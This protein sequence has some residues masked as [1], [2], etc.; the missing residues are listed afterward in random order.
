MLTTRSPNG[1][2]HSR[3]MSPGTLSRSLHAAAFVL[4]PLPSSADSAGLV[5]TFVANSVSLDDRDV[6]HHV[7]V[8]I[9]T[10]RALTTV[11]PHRSL[12]NSMISSTIHLSTSRSLIPLPPTGLPSL[13]RQPLSPTT[14][15]SS[16]S[17]TRWSRLGSMTRRMACTMAP[18]RTLVWLLSRLYRMRSAT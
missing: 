14:K 5:F 12:A 15:R 2:L 8:P 17:S 3:A 13:E 6:H 9:F 7:N 4:T 18:T 10:E 1:L 11:A 16:H